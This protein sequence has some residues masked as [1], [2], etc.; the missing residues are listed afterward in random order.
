MARE[1]QKVSAASAPSPSPGL[2]QWILSLRPDLSAQR[3]VLSVDQPSRWLIETEPDSAEQLRSVLTVFL[4]NREC[5]WRCLM[6]DLWQ[7]TTLHSVP[8]GA[9]PRQIQVALHAASPAHWIKLYNAGSF[10]DSGAIPPSDHAAIAEQCRSFERVVVECHPTLVG[11]RVLAFRDQLNG[12]KLE[13][14]LGLETAHPEVL[15]KLNKRMS[16]Q[17]F[18]R[19]AGFL[20]DSD[21]AV[22]AFVLIKPPYLDSAQAQDWAVR[23]AEFALDS[24]AEVVSLIPTRSGNG[25][26]DELERHGEFSEPSLE[27]VEEVFDKVLQLKRGRVFLDV[28]DLERLGKDEVNYVE[29]RVRLVQMNLSQRV[30]LRV[31]VSR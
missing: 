7:H 9:I 6:C 23:S 16:T 15:A 14:A 8:L 3:R 21:I 22:R 29:R 20:R 28:W 4:T 5:P 17:D 31:G 24:G 2:D 11:P 26:L 1:F 12:T 19:A 10:F 18:A 25:A 13:V 30:L 27:L